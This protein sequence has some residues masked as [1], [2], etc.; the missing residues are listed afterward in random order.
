MR[1]QILF[2]TGLLIMV[3]WL[4]GC[5]TEKV[6]SQFTESQT[7]QSMSAET[8]ETITETEE[9]TTL[10]PETER[11][12][13][14]Y[15]E[16]P[17]LIREPGFITDS[18][19]YCV[20]D[21]NGTVYLGKDEFEPFAPASITKVM[22][23][24]VVSLRVSLD[25]PVTVAEEDLLNV[26][27]M[28]SGVY[29]SLKPDETF[30]VRDLLYTLILPSTNAA[31]NV[32]ARYCAGSTEAFADLMNQK[33]EELG[34]ANSHFMNAHGLDTEGHYTCSY[35]M[36]VIL[37]E[38]LKNPELRTI[39][40]SGIYTLP[41]TAY[42]Q[43][44]VMYVGHAM[45][46]GKVG[47]PG[48]YA[49]KTGWSENAKST[50]VTAIE[51]NGKSF[52]VCTL[53]SEDGRA[54]EDTWNLIETSMGAYFDYEPDILTVVSDY[55]ITA[56]DKKSA[57]LS[58]TI[59]QKA[60][61]AKVLWFDTD[62]GPESVKEI[63]VEK[64]GKETT[65]TLDDLTGELY[66][67]QVYVYDEKDREY[68]KGLI[69]VNTGKMKREGLLTVGTNVYYIDENGF[70]LS[71]NIESP[72]GW[73]YADTSGRLVKGFAGGKFYAGDDY[74]IVTGWFT[75]AYHQYYSGGDGRVVTGKRIVDGVLHEFSSYGALIQ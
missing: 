1:K 10:D 4:I 34:L 23:A 63:W 29:P 6:P 26:A 74:K 61:K 35:D 24:L 72:D 27:V 62:L 52:Y 59:F 9:T 38:A 43:E 39:L 15:K 58:F 32:L 37:R 31:G 53:H 30:T 60:K 8:T 42:E 64:P 22:T 55:K 3:F 12:E 17:H 69:Y 5:G 36:T 73:Y 33:A 67:I 47:C 49:G 21:E 45:L 46:N 11:K 14:L 70:A 20:I 18:D 71:G 28:S 40:G 41:A 48:V 51:R 16:H 13:A 2:L 44:R 68:P 50:L 25:D 65:V 57:E 7:E 66:T 56:C 54:Y 75:D 19:S